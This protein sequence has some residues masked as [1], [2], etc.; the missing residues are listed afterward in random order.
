V[1]LRAF[2]R[3][4]W[5]RRNSIDN[6]TVRADEVL[7][8]K[9]AHLI[10]RNFRE[11]ARSGEDAIETPGKE[12]RVREGGMRGLWEF[13]SWA[14]R[15]ARILCDDAIQFI[16]AGAFSGKV[17]DGGIVGSEDLVFGYVWRIDD[18]GGH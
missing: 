3:R 14:Y 17:F 18:E 10:G 9:G 12:N 16:L 2:P 8:C 5:R 15:S 4:D 6:R 7:G 1:R 13:S 11:V